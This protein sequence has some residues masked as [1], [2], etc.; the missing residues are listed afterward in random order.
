[1]AEPGAVPVKPKGTRGRKPGVPNKATRNAREAIARLVDGKSH[2]LEKWLLE[3]RRLD[4]PQ[5]ALRCFEKLVE[6]HVPKLSRTEHTGA[7]GGPLIIE[8]VRYADSAAVPVGST[9]VSDADVD[10]PGA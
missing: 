8:Q 6:Y 2:L 1:M 7:G 10:R 3:V 9:A 5:A 4:G